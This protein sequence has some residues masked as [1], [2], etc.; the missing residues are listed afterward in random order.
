MFVQLVLVCFYLAV[1]QLFWTMRK[2]IVNAIQESIAALRN[3]N[4][5]DHEGT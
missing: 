4:E 1:W 5:I 3:I 2:S